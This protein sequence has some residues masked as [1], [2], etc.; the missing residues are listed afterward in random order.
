[1]RKYLLLSACLLL[2]ASYSRAV[3]RT[4]SNSPSTLAQFNTIQ[5]AINA[6]NS[7][8]TIYVHGSPNAYTNFTLTNKHLVILG[9]GWSPNKNL[10]F[11]ASVPGFTITG[12]SCANTEIQGMVFTSTIISNASH[13]DTLRFIRNYFQG[14]NIFVNEGGVTY[15]GYLFEGNVFDNSEVNGTGS[16]TYQNFLF[17]NNYFY[18]TGCCVAS[19]IG[20][21]TNS[22][23][24]LFN[25]NL[26]FGPGAST[27]DCFTS[28]CRFLTITNNIFVRRDAANSNSFSTFNNNITFNCGSNGD[29]AWIR[30]SNVNGGGNIAAQNP[31]MVD[32]AA[33]NAG[34][35]NALN[36]FTIAAGP[37]NNSGSD[38]KDIGLLFDATGSL[39]WTNSR[40][41]RL[42]FVFSM[43]IINPT[44]PVSGSLNV[45]VEARK[46][47]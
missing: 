39:N 33:V 16:T 29:T 30:N 8:D 28:N 13:P 41:S 10:P 20:S 36:D 2:A 4:V 26:W 27:R 46:N 22:V 19:S 21:F 12:A 23:N 3:I 25:H 45:Q 32:Q 34:T 43:N 47:N 31:Q 42:P 24:V 14:L 7:G 38:G 6:S 37:A 15:N 40:G 5:A 18:E 35:N 9:P 44:I 1:M 11:T 17:Q